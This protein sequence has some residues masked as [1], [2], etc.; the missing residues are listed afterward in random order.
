MRLT[1]FPAYRPIL[2]FPDPWRSV[3][4]VVAVGGNLLP[5]TLRAAYGQGIFPWPHQGLPLLWFCPLQRAILDFDAL[6]VSE[7]LTKARRKTTLTF[8]IDRAF[9]EV[10]AACS[11]LPRPEQEGTWIT[12][13]MAEAYCEL[14]L[15]GVAHSV[16]AWDAAGNLVGGLYGVDSGG[17]FSG[18]SMFFRVPNASKLALLF[19]IDHL[20]AQ[21]LDFM[22]IQQLTP[23]MEAFGAREISRNAFLTR[24]AA[25]RSRHLTLF[26][27][28]GQSSRTARLLPPPL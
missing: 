11:L 22:D 9:P 14:H 2:R 20:S 12:P 5:E 26:P 10:I 25:T 4:D 8:T 24:W 17:T 7:S 16:E 19:L 28:V 27:N 18:E 3:G 13:E 21:G 23:H 15:Q 6:H 1:F